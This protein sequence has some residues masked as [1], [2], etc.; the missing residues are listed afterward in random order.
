MEPPPSNAW[1]SL[2]FDRGGRTGP[3]RSNYFF[4]RPVDDPQHLIEAAKRGLLD[5][6]L[7]FDAVPSSSAFD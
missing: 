5:Q 3:P 4:S 7:F 2:A 1:S 6:M